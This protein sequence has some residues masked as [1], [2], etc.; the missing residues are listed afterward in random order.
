MQEALI[1]QTVPRILKSGTFAG[2]DGFLF[3]HTL[4]R[5]VQWLQNNG[6]LLKLNSES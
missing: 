3:L 6:E 4:L 2:L 1:A 5:K